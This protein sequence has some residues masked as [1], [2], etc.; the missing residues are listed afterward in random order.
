MMMTV[1]IGTTSWTLMVE[2]QI[3][4]ILNFI[5]D[6]YNLKTRKC[7]FA[8]VL[9]SK[10]WT[11]LGHLPQS[12]LFILFLS[13]GLGWQ[14]EFSTPGVQ[15]EILFPESFICV[16]VLCLQDIC[17]WSSSDA[18]MCIDVVALFIPFPFLFVHC[19]LKLIGV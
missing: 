13:L 12:K 19:L 10:I 14:V 4:F 15:M 18:W 8:F 7:V 3:P 2:R 6:V 17:F 5:S 1:F 11:Y 16:T 9:T